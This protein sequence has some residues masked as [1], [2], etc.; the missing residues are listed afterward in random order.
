MYLLDEGGGPAS[1]DRPT[2]LIRGIRDPV[3]SGNQDH[4]ACPQAIL[5]ATPPKPAGML[6][7]PWDTGLI[8]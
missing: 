8:K 1:L 7:Q 6:M 3:S 5:D 2:S 4:D